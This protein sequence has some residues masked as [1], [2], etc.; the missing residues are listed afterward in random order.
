MTSE[1]DETSPSRGDEADE[2]EEKR[3][4]RPYRRLVGIIFTVAVVIA[5]VVILRGIIRH[6]DRMPTVDALSKPAV[7]DVRAL[8]AC[9]EDLGKL[10]VS[11]RQSAGALI[12]QV[13]LDE[14]P[15]GDWESLS[16]Q[17]EIDRLGIVARCRLNEPSDDAV[18]SDLETASSE[19]D[20]LIR[21]Y[22]LLYSRHVGSGLPHA[23]EARAA[24]KRANAAISAR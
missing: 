20:A 15:A 2:T 4:L 24:L 8:R 7:V 14:K 11:V 22:A 16:R 5:S 17:L 19:L 1:E 9:A 18:V 13:P 6:L 23:I 10:E 12:S 21:A 3:Q